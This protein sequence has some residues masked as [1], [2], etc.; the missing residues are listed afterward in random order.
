MHDLF[1]PPSMPLPLPGCI[2]IAASLKWESVANVQGENL[3]HVTLGKLPSCRAVH[4]K[5]IA[6]GHAGEALAL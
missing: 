3:V 4:I 1:T 6:N 2:P 5:A